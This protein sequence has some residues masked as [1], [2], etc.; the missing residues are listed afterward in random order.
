M[1]KFE[2]ELPTEIMKDFEKIYK[3]SEKIFGEMTRAGAEVVNKNIQAN[4]PQS[5]RQSKM[6][7]CL[8]M[9]RTYKTSRIVAM[10][11]CEPRS[12]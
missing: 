5:I 6:M 9:T 8:K 11:F 7:D 12:C 4:V 1:A 10:S 3:D 2:M